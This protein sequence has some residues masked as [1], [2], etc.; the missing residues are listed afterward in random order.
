MRPRRLFLEDALQW[1]C[2]ARRQLIA[3]ILDP[4]VVAR[5]LESLGLPTRPPPVRAARAPPHDDQGEDQQG[6]RQLLEPH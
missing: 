1:E 6:S 5:I 3:L 4:P 2:G